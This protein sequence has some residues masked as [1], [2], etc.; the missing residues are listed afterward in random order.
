MEKNFAQVFPTC[1]LN[2]TLDTLFSDVLVER[3]STN[4]QKDF[5]RIYL[6]SDH[7]LPKQAVYDVEKEIKNQLFPKVNMTIKIQE[8]FSLSAQY[9]VKTLLDTYKDSIMTE[10]AGYSHI[11]HTALRKADFHAGD[12]TLELILEDRKSVV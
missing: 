4:K 1:K 5:L 11:L 2:K 6:R 7:L 12:D 3:V 9:T 10:I 8:K